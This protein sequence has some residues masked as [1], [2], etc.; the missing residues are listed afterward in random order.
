MIATS[1]NIRTG[2][3]TRNGGNYPRPHTSRLAALLARRTSKSDKAA[4]HDLDRV[5][6]TLRHLASLVAA[7][8]SVAGQVAA[9]IGPATI[10][11][12]LPAVPKFDA[13][14]M[15]AAQEADIA[16][17]LAEARYLAHPTRAN[18][19]AM[20][21]ALSAQINT[22]RTLLAAIGEAVAE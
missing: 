1:E 2:T 20:R 5:R 13:D 18:L 16:E 12:T 6:D 15:L 21:P 10:V 9:L 14:L 22:S 11:T 19:L 8:P 7:D 3:R 17:D 4:Q